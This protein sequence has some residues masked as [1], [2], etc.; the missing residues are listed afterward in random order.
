MD[1]ANVIPSMYVIIGLPLNLRSAMSSGHLVSMR[2]RSPYSWTSS[3]STCT[4]HVGK[5]QMYPRWPSLPRTT[6]T[7]S[8]LLGSQLISVPILGN[9]VLAYTRRFLFSLMIL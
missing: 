1:A 4:T 7:I 9:V 8:P 5:L 3:S 6:G 2:A